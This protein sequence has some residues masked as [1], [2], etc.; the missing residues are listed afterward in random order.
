MAFHAMQLANPIDGYTQ[1]LNIL[2]TDILNASYYT[3]IVESIDDVLPVITAQLDA[4]RAWLEI[5]SY[6]VGLF[7]SSPKPPNSKSIYDLSEITAMSGL[8]MYLCRTVAK[9]IRNI[10]KLIFVKNLFNRI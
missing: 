9:P 3:D 2:V 1:A 10:A 6:L 7:G 8:L 5:E 4:K